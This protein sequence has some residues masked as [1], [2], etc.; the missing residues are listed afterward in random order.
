M[1]YA[2]FWA[3]LF[4]KKYFDYNDGMY[5]GKL[6]DGNIFAYSAWGSL[7]LILSILYA[8]ATMAFGYRFSNLT[9][10][11]IITNGPYKW[12][13]HPAY[14]FKNLSWWLISVPFVPYVSV[15]TSI[16]CCIILLLLNTVY[17][18]RAR[19]EENHLS[20]YPEYV[21]YAN[22]VNENGIFRFVGKLFPYL[23]YSEKR[24]INSNS[25][26]YKP[27]TQRDKLTK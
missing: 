2:P 9:Y 12:T 26:V 25:K 19:T 8:Y 20:N 22:W 15:S 6:L 4:Q 27:F 7:I 24:A 18:I 21:E 16:K 1:G 14:I 3:D 23:K 17:Y 13:K 5:W 11:G 10:R